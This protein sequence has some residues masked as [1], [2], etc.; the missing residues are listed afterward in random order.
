LGIGISN[1]TLPENA[2]G[3]ITPSDVSSSSTL[4][5]GYAKAF[6]AYWTTMGI[7][8]TYN[9]FDA[10]LSRFLGLETL[11][12]GTNPSGYV[13]IL[14]NGADPSYGGSDTGSSATFGRTDLQQKSEGYFH[15]FKDSAFINPPCPDPDP[16]KPMTLLCNAAPKVAFPKQH[17]VFSGLS[18]VG[19]TFGREDSSLVQK[20]VGAASGVFTPTV[21]FRYTPED[22]QCHV[23]SHPEIDPDTCVFEDDADYLGGIAYRTKQPISSL[24]HIGVTGSLCQGLNP[25]LFSRMAAHP[26]KVIAGAVLL[27]SAGILANATYNY[28]KEDSELASW[29]K[30]AFVITPLALGALLLNCL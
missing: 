29:Q 8:G 6:K 14:L 9:L 17:G 4:S 27:V 25:D 26:D 11:T 18:S 13:N 5:S 20:V 30:N 21:K 7:W 1:T 15:V 2:H 23:S 19:Y 16:L 12:H 10:G 22:A 28:V 3:V 24:E